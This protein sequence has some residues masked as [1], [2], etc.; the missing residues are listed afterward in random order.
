MIYT[1]TLCLRNSSFSNRRVAEAPAWLRLRLLAFTQFVR[2][3]WP[4]SA[5]AWV[6]SLS[7]SSG[8]ETRDFFRLT[9][10]TS[11]T[12]NEELEE[13]GRAPSS[14]DGVDCRGAESRSATE[15]VRF[16]CSGGGGSGLRNF[17]EVTNGTLDSN[18][19][20]ENGLTY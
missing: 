7:S 12:S 17:L 10:S 6:P 2:L 1:A 19:G 16:L 14:A 20:T 8:M 3:A 13:G 11:S 18:L 9:P 4:A 5:S 15:L